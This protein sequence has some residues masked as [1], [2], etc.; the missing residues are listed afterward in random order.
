LSYPPADRPEILYDQVLGARPPLF[1]FFSRVREE[2]LAGKELVRFSDTLTELCLDP[3]RDEPRAH[4]PTLLEGGIASGSFCPRVIAPVAGVRNGGG[5]PIAPARKVSYF[6]RSPLFS[7]ELRVIQ[8]WR[9]RSRSM[10][11][12]D[13]K[14]ACPIPLS[15]TCTRNA[16][17]SNILSVFLYR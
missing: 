15:F 8:R 3:R 2:D 11:L 7:P 10:S 9:L 5:V 4:P 1:F 14:V 17:P 16:P 12:K 6:P 13:S